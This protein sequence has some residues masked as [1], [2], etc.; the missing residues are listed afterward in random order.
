MVIKKKH[1]SW[2]TVR[3]VAVI[4]SRSAKLVAFSI[5][6]GSFLVHYC[7]SRK[8][9][10]GFVITFFMLVIFKLLFQA[11]CSPIELALL[12][13]ILCT[14]ITRLLTILTQFLEKLGI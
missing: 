7:K 9:C 6:H 2:S 1:T 3:Y 8:S 11:F 10:T 12:L 13:S 4:L 5:Y 14:F